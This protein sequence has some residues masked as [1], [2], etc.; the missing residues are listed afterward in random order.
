MQEL[1]ALAG[2]AN[3]RFCPFESVRH[4]FFAIDVYAGIEEVDRHWRVPEVGGGDNHS[5]KFVS[6]IFY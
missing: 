1:S 3:H 6:V 2:G 5:V 4:H